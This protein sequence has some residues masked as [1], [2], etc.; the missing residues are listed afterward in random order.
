MKTLEKEKNTAI[1]STIYK[2]E[3]HFNA[4][5]NNHIKK[6]KWTTV[7]KVKIEATGSTTETTSSN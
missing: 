7:R 1:L 4:L 3:N 2:S 6:L 5:T